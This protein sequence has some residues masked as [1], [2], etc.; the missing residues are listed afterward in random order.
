[1]VYKHVRHRVEDNA[2][3][4]EGFSDHAPGPAGRWRDR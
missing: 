3:W 2:R 4:R 1:M